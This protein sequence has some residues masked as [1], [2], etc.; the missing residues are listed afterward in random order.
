MKTAQLKVYAACDTDD[1]GYARNQLA[2]FPIAA[3]ASAYLAKEG[4]S[5]GY[6]TVSCLNGIRIADDIFLVDKEISKEKLQSTLPTF[7]A[8]DGYEDFVYENGW[9]NSKYYTNWSQIQELLNKPNKRV[10]LR[11]VI[12]F[13][14]EEEIFLLQKAEPIKMQPFIMSREIA[15]AHA[16]SKLTEEE[17]KLLGLA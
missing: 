1:R 9:D 4:P 14:T 10:S 16:L 6:S 13:R 11:K 17:R 8:I 15:T 7:Q 3:A 12:L 2:F 5:H